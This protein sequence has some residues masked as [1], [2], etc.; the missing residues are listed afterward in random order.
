[1]K[2]INKKSSRSL[3]RLRESVGEHPLGLGSG[4]F[5]THLADDEKKLLPTLLE[6]HSRLI[7][8]VAGHDQGLRNDQFCAGGH[9]LARRNELIARFIHPQE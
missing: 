8:V 1:M 4:K 6:I 5:D 2:N 3:D 7:T 9:H